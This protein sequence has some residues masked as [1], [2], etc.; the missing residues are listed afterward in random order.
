MPDTFIIRVE[1]KLIEYMEG[2]TP[3]CFY[4]KKKIYRGSDVCFNIWY[5]VN[6]ELQMT[7][8]YHS[9]CKTD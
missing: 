1:G 4:C 6:K 2:D 8:P 5:N 3:E 9:K 7:P